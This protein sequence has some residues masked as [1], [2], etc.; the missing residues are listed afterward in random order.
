MTIPFLITIGSVLA[1][2]VLAI[3]ILINSKRS[4]SSFYFFIMVA[5]ITGWIVSNYLS[6]YAGDYSLALL[7]NKLIFIT[8][9]I[10]AWSFVIF[11]QYFPSDK[12]IKIKY[13][14]IPTL[15]CI[16]ALA[17]SS[18]QYLVKSI[19]I[20]ESVSEIVFGWGIYYYLAFF[21]GCL[22]FS[23]YKFVVDYIKSNDKNIKKTVQALF[24]VF[25]A[26][27]LIS[28]ITNLVLPVVLSNFNFTNLAPIYTI[29]FIY[30][31]A[32]VILKFRFLN[33]KVI[34][35]ELFAS[36]LAAIIFVEIFQGVNLFDVIFRIIIFV[37]TFVF[38]V[39]LIRSVILEVKRR[40]DMEILNEKLHI[41]TDKLQAANK[42]LQR[43]DDAKSEFL[44]IASH[45]LRTPVTIIKGYASMIIEGSYGKVSKKIKSV[46]INVSL[47]NDRL[48]NLI[49]NLL[50]ISRIEAGRLEFDLKPIVLADVVRPIVADFQQKAKDKGLKLEFY[51][52]EKIPLVM[53]DVKKISEV[54]SN[55][56]DNSVKYTPRG[57][58][59]VS[60][61]EEGTSGVFACQDTGL[62]II[63]KDLPRLFHKFVRGQDMMK[64]HTEGT[65]LGMYF[66]R[67]VVENMG[68]RIW[69]ESPGKNRGSKFSFS[70]PL[71]DRK[72]AKKIKTA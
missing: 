11:S 67:T 48:L 30:A 13:L 59:I 43:L 12:K 4:K 69:A 23:F 57:E 56:I 24:V 66:A 2:L 7:Y 33:V 49:E 20:K 14:L 16:I 19:I 55:I 71:A 36:F 38:A 47:A 25:G 42:E 27:L 61:H 63:S 68:G 53:A 3:V 31:I 44:S 40:E 9:S 1:S 64:V 45:Q 50:D 29:L 70:L 8:T 60:L 41:T 54:I 39:F 6:N 52:N 22:I 18:S 10:F 62:G 65:G 35:T 72:K 34:A 26:Y 46:M 5:G 17:I 51:E 28:V 32:W 21:I 37:I 58:I 15:L